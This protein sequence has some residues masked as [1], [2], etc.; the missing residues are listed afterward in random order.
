M[1]IQFT[2]EQA[3]ELKRVAAEREI[4]VAAIAR[5]AVERLLIENGD[6]TSAE[7]RAKA[8]E[9]MGKFRSGRSDVAENHDHYLDE[10]YGDRG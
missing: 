3:R 8:L 4:S 1:Q 9:I 7:G 2:E 10:I 5:E 6:S